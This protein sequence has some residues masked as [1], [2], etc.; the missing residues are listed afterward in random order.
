MLL[1]LNSLTMMYIFKVDVPLCDLTVTIYIT[2]VNISMFWSLLKQ[3]VSIYVAHL[4][5]KYT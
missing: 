1:K 5:A 4:Q 2:T 3:H